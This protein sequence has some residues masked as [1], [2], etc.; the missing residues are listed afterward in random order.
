MT[1]IQV[2]LTRDLDSKVTRNAACRALAKGEVLEV[3]DYGIIHGERHI[4]YYPKGS[5]FDTPI[6]FDAVEVIQG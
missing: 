6:P 1:K 5:F 2:R 4:R 3:E